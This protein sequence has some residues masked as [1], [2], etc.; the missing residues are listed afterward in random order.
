M[1]KMKSDKITGLFVGIEETDKQ[2]TSLGTQFS[3]LEEQSA[4]ISNNLKAIQKQFDI[5]Q[6]SLDVI[7]GLAE[8]MFPEAYADFQKEGET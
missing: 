7:Q 4:F 6:N 3:S 5:M 8:Q 1:K 2:I